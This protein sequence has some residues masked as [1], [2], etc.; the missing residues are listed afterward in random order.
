M[1]EDESSREL[2]DGVGWAALAGD[3][4]FDDRR[5]P[6]G[7]ILL[8]MIIRAKVLSIPGMY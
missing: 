6:D 7:K 5:F 2:G 4:I 8:S 1:V 3:S